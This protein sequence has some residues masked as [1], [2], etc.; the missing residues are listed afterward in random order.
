M[1]NYRPFFVC[2]LL[3]NCAVVF[4]QVNNPNRL[5]FNW[6][7]DLSKTDIDLSEVTVVV[8]KGAFP[9][10]KNPKFIDRQ[11]GLLTFYSNEPVLVVNLAGE[12]RAYPLNMLT[13]HEIANDQ[14][15]DT[16]FLVTYCPLCNSGMVF[17]RNVELNGQTQTLD[18][19]VS[20]MLRNSDMIMFDNQT[21]T[22]WQQLTGEG[23]AGK[24]NGTELKVIPSVVLS[25]S[26]FF[27]RYPQ[28]KILSKEG[29]GVNSKSYGQNPYVGYDALNGNPYGGFIKP[30]KLTRKLPN[31]ERVVGLRINQKQLIYPFTELR[32][33]KVV[34]DE[35]EGQKIV[36]FY[37]SGTVSVLDTYKISEGKDVG[38]AVIYKPIVEGQT[39]TFKEKKGYFYDV[40]TNSKWDITGKCLSGKHEGKQLEIEPHGIHLAFAWLAF[41]P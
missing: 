20:G 2:L 5:S 14:I 9:V 40:Q 21:E 41:Y 22:W 31:M 3:F 38:T 4:S 26:D 35:F 30:E 32:K 8:Q 13:I 33:K 36:V 15:G 23:I 16:R 7:T 11:K 19:E 1:R 24:L 37:K 12:A 17:D 34:N 18:F 25:V 27:E 10:L 6:K 39:L 28:G 29:S